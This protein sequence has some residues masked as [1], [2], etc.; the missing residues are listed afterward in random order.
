[1]TIR[2][3]TARDVDRAY[4]INELSPPDV[5][6][7]D[8]STFDSL[9]ERSVVALGALD[10]ASTM[11][12]FCF[13]SAAGPGR[14]PARSAWALQRDDA[15]LHI[16]RVAFAPGGGGQGLGVELFDEIDRNVGASTPGSGTKLTSLVRVDPPNT[17]GWD[18]HLARGFVEID[19]ATFDDVTVALMQRRYDA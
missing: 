10:A 1:V 12:G 11:V 8:R 18:F 2:T 15:E 5:D 19:R 16:E 6:S 14:L 13:I 4:E 9:Y 17:H 3:L 7:V